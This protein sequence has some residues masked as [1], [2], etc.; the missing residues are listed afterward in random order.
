MDR[1]TAY[2]SHSYRH[3][4]RKVNEFFWNL[5]W[6]NGITFAVD[7]ESE[8]LSI[9]YLELMMKRSAAFVGVITRR[10]E[11]STYQC[12]PFMV[13]EHGLAVQA[14]KPRLLL[15]ESGVSKYFFPEGPHTL[16]FSRQAL[17]SI[18]AEVERRIGLLSQSSDMNATALGH[19]LGKVGLLIGREARRRGIVRD[20]IK[21]LGFTPVNLE[22]GI[23]DAFRFAIQ[24]D[25]LDFIVLDMQYTEL[26]PWLYP[27]II[28]R[29][30]PTIRIRSEPS[31]QA[32]RFAEPPWETDDLLSTVAAP[33]ELGVS[34]QTSSELKSGLVKHAERLREER[35]L[36]RSLSEGS[37]YF[38]SLGRKRGR[39]FISGATEANEFSR[40]LSGALS[41][42]NIPHFHYRFQND[43]ELAARW[44]E[45]LPERIN[46]S[47][48]FVP[49]ITEGYWHSEFCVREY[50]LARERADIG[51]LI[52]VPYFL[53]S[54]GSGDI[55]EQGRDLSGLAMREQ[56][57]R[58]VTDMD[59][60]LTAEEKASGHADSHVD[61]PVRAP[62]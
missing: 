59:S 58:V 25:E 57:R 4:D 19:G 43:I 52:I 48:Y 32:Y 49:L 26:P 12:S 14:Q 46:S 2:L 23:T 5:F 36:L 50:S 29:F 53:T 28:G 41:R 39:I 6:R 51:N 38:R 60:K 18:K 37:R 22:I 7:P 56:V 13:F 42:E 10:A 33:D 1:I 21:N 8:P 17:P 62:D 55:P 11:E 24:L 30:I 35:I 40:H 9:P 61:R 15:V 16:Y 20:V 3:G 54:S 45:K 47:Q 44:E 31:K 27:F 34:Y